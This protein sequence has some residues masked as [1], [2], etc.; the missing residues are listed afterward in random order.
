MI[1]LGEG[2][3]QGWRD[4]QRP[5]WYVKDSSSP[6]QQAEFKRCRTNDSADC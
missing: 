3:R 4:L 2:S 6:I 1:Q 5:D